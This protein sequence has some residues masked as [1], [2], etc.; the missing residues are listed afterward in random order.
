MFRTLFI[1]HVAVRECGS[2]NVVK[3]FSLNRLCVL[4][5]VKYNIAIFPT[6]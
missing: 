1:V 5:T 3:R 6:T 4:P 2:S